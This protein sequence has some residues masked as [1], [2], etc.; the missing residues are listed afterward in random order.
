MNV[1]ILKFHKNK[2]SNKLFQKLAWIALS[3][4]SRRNFINCLR[5]SVN[6]PFVIQPHL[7]MLSD[8]FLDPPPYLKEL[9]IH[10]TNPHNNLNNYTFRSLATFIIALQKTEIQQTLYWV[11]LAFPLSAY[12]SLSCWMTTFTAIEYKL[13]KKLLQFVMKNAK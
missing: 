6:I 13:V 5:V 8:M 4:Q 7:H 12:I 10:F 11:Y 1:S 2:L 9:S 3:K